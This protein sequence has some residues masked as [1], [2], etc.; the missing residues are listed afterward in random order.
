MRIAGLAGRIVQKV[1]VV[2]QQIGAGDIYAALERGTIDAAEWVGPFDDEKLGFAKVAPFYYAPGWWEAGPSTNLFIN[3]AKWEELPQSYRAIVQAAAA[4]ATQVM[5]TRYDADNTAA[6]KRLVG[7]NVQLR[8]FS[9]EILDACW[10]ATDEVYAEIAASN[11]IFKQMLDH[12]T[13]FRKDTATWF[14]IAETSLEAYTQSALR[15]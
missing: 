2:P 9:R 4:Q 7:G 8:F 15:R 13:T 10:K 6:L 3:K 5:L 14:A 11:P 12:W 1:G